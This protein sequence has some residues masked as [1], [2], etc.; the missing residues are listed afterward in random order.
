VVVWGG[1]DFMD[2]LG[3]GGRYYPVGDVWGPVTLDGAPS[4]RTGHT[5]VWTGNEMIVWGGN[6]SNSG[7]RYDPYGDAWVATSLIGAPEGRSS[8][9]AVWTGNEMLV[10]GGGGSNTGARYD[11]DLDR[12]VATSLTGAPEGRSRHTAVWTG[13]EMVVWGGGD[14]Y[15]P[16][17]TGGRYDPVTDSWDSTTI[18]GAPLGRRSHTALWT[19]NRMVVWGGNE[20]FGDL[21]SGGRYDPYNDAWEAT[22]LDEAPSPRD[23]HSA[24]WTGNE[25]LVWGGFG[26]HETGGRYDP[27]GPDDD[28]DGHGCAIDCD[29][30]NPDAFAVP[31][32]VRGMRFAGDADTFEWNAVVAGDATTYDVV[33]GLQDELPVGGGPSEVCLVADHTPDGGTSDTVSWTDPGIPAP[34]GTFWYL[35]RATNACGRGTYGAGN[36]GAPRSTEA[37]Q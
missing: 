24:V 28:G 10:W 22:S 21:Q 26:P 27:E 7:A 33:R 2:E 29:D 23:G 31:G 18:D 25:M 19:G 17:S 11:P 20:G 1:Y 34:G 6:G 32:E 8:H 15:N 4:P 13:D 12:W 35:V 5:A 16:D 37:C 30:T 14:Y 36:H 9:T 3:T